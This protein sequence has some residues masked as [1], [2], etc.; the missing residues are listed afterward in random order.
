M[1]FCRRGGLS[2][3]GN[4]GTGVGAR[5]RGRGAGETG[6]VGGWGK[7]VCGR[8]G[9]AGGTSPSHPRPNVLAIDPKTGENGLRVFL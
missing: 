4:R 3:E 2:H 9:M 6:G 5:E 1:S 8:Y 7:G